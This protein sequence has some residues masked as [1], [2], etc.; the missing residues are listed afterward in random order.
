MFKT[1]IISAMLMLVGVTVASPANAG[2]Y[3]NALGSSPSLT[4]AEQ[5]LWD[6]VVNDVDTDV[7]A[8][9]IVNNCRQNYQIVMDA[10]HAIHNQLVNG[11]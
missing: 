7:F 5:V 4:K 9:D 6:A 3:C 1:I 11:G 8:T 2:P 10:A